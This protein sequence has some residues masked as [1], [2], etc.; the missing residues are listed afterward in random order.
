SV[1]LGNDDQPAMPHVPAADMAAS[2]MSLSGIL[3]ALYRRDR[4]GQGDHLDISMHDSIL[5]WTPNVLGP[6]FVEKRPPVPKHERTWGGAAFYRIYRTADNRH[7]VLGGQEAKF[8]RN[9]LNE[10]ARPDLI[11]LCDRGP[12]PHQQPVVEF[13]QDVFATRT[14]AEWVEW[15]DGRDICFAPVKNLREAFDDPQVAARDMRLVDEQGQEHIG[16]PIRFQNEPGQVEFALPTLGE[17][18][19]EVLQEFGYS[20]AEIEAMQA[21]GA[22]HAP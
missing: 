10:L 2:L 15:F 6:V 17:H 18:T 21:A 1:N 13:L 19:R 9:L 14:Q 5:A 12:G 16:I 7:V 4:T 20:A 3:M 22:C 11:E 8:V